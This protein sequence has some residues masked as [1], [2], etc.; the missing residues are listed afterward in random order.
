MPYH[1]LL[2]PRIPVSHQPTELSSVSG[3]TEHLCHSFSTCSHHPLT[4]YSAFIYSLRM[5][6]PQRRRKYI[7]ES[8]REKELKEL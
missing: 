1:G 6:S 2:W 4:P 5:P 7:K 3:Y 8:W